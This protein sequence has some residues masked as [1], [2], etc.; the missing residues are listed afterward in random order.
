M[1]LK[2]ILDAQR[3]AYAI[4]AIIEILIFSIS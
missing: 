1:E 3:N 2:E 4:N